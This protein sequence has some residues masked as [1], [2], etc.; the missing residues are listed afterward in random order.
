M[1]METVNRNEKLLELLDEVRI[2]RV[3]HQLAATDIE[4]AAAVAAFYALGEAKDL[5]D[6]AVRVLLLVSTGLIGVA[7]TIVQKAI[8]DARREKEYVQQIHE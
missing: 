2:Q 5:G 7:M 8:D 1:S 4:A 6:T 3:R